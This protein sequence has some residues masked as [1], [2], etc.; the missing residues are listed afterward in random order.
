VPDT[1]T[2]ALRRT[3]MAAIRGRDTKPELIVRR[4]A[5]RL[6]FRFRPH[7]ALRGGT[8]TLATRSPATMAAATITI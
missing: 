5:H 2:P 7:V 4:I 6:G 8:A 3:C 1:L